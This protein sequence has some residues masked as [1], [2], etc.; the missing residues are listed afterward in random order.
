MSSQSLKNNGVN[1]T[2]TSC[3]GASPG[4]GP[5]CEQAGLGR[6]LV[7]V[8]PDRNDN[9]NNT[10]KRRKKWTRDENMFVMECYF[11][12]SPRRLGYRKGI[13]QL[14]NDKGLFI[15]TEQR[16]VDQAGYLI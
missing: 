2:G 4:R 14:W 5:V 15:I 16:L 9:D 12:S 8:S 3:E 7:T 13:L 11:R 6:H 1:G 10:R